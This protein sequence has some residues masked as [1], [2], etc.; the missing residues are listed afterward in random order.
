MRPRV[1]RLACAPAWKMHPCAL[2]SKRG[3]VCSMH[4]CGLP[5]IC[6]CGVHTEG[7]PRPLRPVFCGRKQHC[8]SPCKGLF[9]VGAWVDITSE[10]LLVLPF[11]SV[12][13][14]LCGTGAASCSD[15]CALPVQ[16]RRAPGIGCCGRGGWRRKRGAQG[17]L[18]T[19]KG[20]S[21]RL[22]VT[23][24]H[25]AATCSRCVPLARPVSSRAGCS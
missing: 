10:M 19:D 23:V 2:N 12:L 16:L 21:C 24:S 7:L 4:G 15:V 6:C 13:H 5:L 8:G 18:G 20:V 17:G 14:C 9:G 1:S 25:M 3:M 22:I 11:K